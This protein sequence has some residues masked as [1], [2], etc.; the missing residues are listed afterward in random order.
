MMG[1]DRGSA[2]IEALVSTAIVAGVLAT[3]FAAIDQAGARR[4]DIDARRTAL[5][6]ARSEMAAVGGE[7]ALT[8]GQVEGVQGDFRWRV[9]IDPDQAASLTTS[10]AGAPALVSVSVRPARG[11][12]DLVTLR[13]LRL[14]TTQ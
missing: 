7:I 2:F 14:A 6:I 11:G 12:E 9:R 13:T 5:L 1:D 10:L 3:L 4:R 8:P